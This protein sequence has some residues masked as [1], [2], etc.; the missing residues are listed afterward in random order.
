MRTYGLIAAAVL[1][2][3]QQLKAQPAPWPPPPGM[4]AG[5]YVARYGHR[6]PPPHLEQHSYRPRGY[7]PPPGYYYERPRR[8]R[9]HYYD[10]DDF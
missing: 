2:S 5:E 6:I 9:R 3:T 7:G 4:T 10:D 8:S 1:L